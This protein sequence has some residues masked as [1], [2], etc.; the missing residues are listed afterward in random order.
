MGCMQIVVERSSM[1]GT[2]LAQPLLHVLCWTQ[3]D[4]CDS[5]CHMPMYLWA[6]MD[7]DRVVPCCTAGWC[8]QEA[9]DELTAALRTLDSSLDVTNSDQDAAGLNG[10]AGLARAGSQAMQ[11]T[12][13]D[14]NVQLQL[15]W[16]RGY[17]VLSIGLVT[18]GGARPGLWVGL[19]KQTEFYPG[20]QLS[21]KE[22]EPAEKVRVV[23]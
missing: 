15:R 12:V 23:G 17:Q 1:L 14:S 20:C 2:A 7:V 21:R 13:S 6:T 19:N 22:S 9:H 16:D 3:T 4:S 5:K 8:T 10:G 11:D 18:S